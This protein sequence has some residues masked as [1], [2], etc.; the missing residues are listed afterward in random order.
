MSL[1]SP[2]MAIITTQIQVQ[3]ERNYLIITSFI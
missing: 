1:L 3:D 2:G